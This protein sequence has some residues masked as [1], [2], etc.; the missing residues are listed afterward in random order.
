MASFTPSSMPHEA[1][2]QQALAA[3]QASPN[4]RASAALAPAVQAIFDFLNSKPQFISPKLATTIQE[5][6]RGV[7]ADA[8]PAN[9]K[10]T[11][12]AQTLGAWVDTQIRSQSAS[13]MVT[14]SSDSLHV[15]DVAPSGSATSL[16]VPSPSPVAVLSGSAALAAKGKTPSPNAD[17]MARARGASPAMFADGLEHAEQSMSP[18]L[19]KM[20][21]LQGVA[22]KAELTTADG[23][24]IAE[25]LT[26]LRDDG[27]LPSAILDGHASG[28]SAAEG[29]KGRARTGT[30]SKIFGKGKAKAAEAA[31]E[32]PTLRTRLNDAIAIASA[33]GT[34]RHLGSVEDGAPSSA[35]LVQLASQMQE[36]SPALRIAA[37]QVGPYVERMRADGGGMLGPAVTRLQEEG[38]PAL[39]AAIDAV[40]ALQLHANLQRSG[41]QV[42][43]SLMQAVEQV[44]ALQ[45]A[46][47]A[48][49]A[50]EAAAKAEAMV[51]KGKA[52]TDATAKLMA[53]VATF[54]VRA[55]VSTFFRGQEPIF[56]AM[57]GVLTAS[58]AR[59]PRFEQTVMRRV[60]ADVVAT[61]EPGLVGRLG[62][63]I[64]QHE[65]IQAAMKGGQPIPPGSPSPDD[66]IALKEKLT[67]DVQKVVTSVAIHTASELWSAVAADAASFPPEY[68]AA[69]CA[70]LDRIDREGGSAEDIAVKKD[71]V[72]C[73]FLGLRYLLPK[74][75]T[76]VLAGSTAPS[77]AGGVGARD[78][79][80]SSVGP[81]VARHFNSVIMLSASPGNIEP[82]KVVNFTAEQIEDLRGAKAAFNQAVAVLTG[83]ASAT[84]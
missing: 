44:E 17:V 83:R 15:P 71:R 64:Q 45:H 56:A 54:D 42:H 38:F 68:R 7:P 27:L 73:N 61:L 40:G 33:M 4:S 21:A 19:S 50:A 59:D 25:A 43:E 18:A 47:A 8:I 30:L 39:S 80:A 48:A 70:L 28:T 36:L 75:T 52:V 69:W 57:R 11:L 37:S 58:E 79:S 35:M 20:M 81:V 23:A 72:S 2:L 29:T 74:I 9:V 84:S 77:P 10:G 14:G 49:A 3:I 12:G 13:A 41:A 24:V 34:Q 55:E 63:S 66:A 53:E 82:A 62:A 76:Q 65:A 22:Q 16:R 6:A 5:F 51:A 78:P 31:K 60:P 46:Q 1:R 32:E 67:A 26:A